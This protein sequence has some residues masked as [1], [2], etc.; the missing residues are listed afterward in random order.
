MTGATIRHMG[1]QFI[2][3]SD[4]DR[5]PLRQLLVA[6]LGGDPLVQ[7]WTRDLEDAERARLL[8][9]RTSDIGGVPAWL[10]D[11]TSSPVR[12]ISATRAGSDLALKLAHSYEL[13]ELVEVFM[14]DPH[15]WRGCDPRRIFAELDLRAGGTGHATDWCAWAMQRD[16]DQV[17]SLPRRGL[18]E[19]EA[20]HHRD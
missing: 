11:W 12:R 10:S 8:E 7:G 20:H 5:P 16:R 17:V 3:A 18:D 1:I 13:C 15:G 19:P 6:C 9:S 4:W 2:Q 14:E